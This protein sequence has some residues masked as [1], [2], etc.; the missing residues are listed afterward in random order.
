VPA[1]Q[2]LADNFGADHIVMGTDYPYD[3]GD[4]KPCETVGAL[5]LAEK[6]KEL[7]RYGN[8][9]RLLKTA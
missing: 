4:Y 8:C 9:N 7:I 1:L 6:D 5:R 2:F 3:M